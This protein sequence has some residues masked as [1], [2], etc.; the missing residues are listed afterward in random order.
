MTI[1]GKRSE[2]IKLHLLALLGHVTVGAARNHPVA[3]RRAAP[4]ESG[5]LGG[6]KSRR[7]S[8]D[9]EARLDAELVTPDNTPHTVGAPPI[10]RR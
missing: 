4:V 8:P 10:R 6:V 1:A 3:D 9:G 7:T 5:P 2:I